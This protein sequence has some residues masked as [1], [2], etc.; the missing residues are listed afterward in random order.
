[1]SKI[2]IQGDMLEA[3][4]QGADVL[5]AHRRTLRVPLSAIEAVSVGIPSVVLREPA[6][7]WGNY[8]VGEMLV[9]NVDAPDGQ[10]ESFFEVRNPARAL[11][12]ELSRGRFAF[13]VLEPSNT[14]PEQLVEALDIARGH[15]LPDAKL[16]PDLMP[17]DLDEITLPHRAIHTVT[18]EHTSMNKQVSATNPVHSPITPPVTPNNPVWWNDANTSDWERVK[19]ALRRDWEQT[20]ADFSIGNARELNQN[21]FDTL[22]QAAGDQPVPL[23]T[24]KTRPDT[25]GELA[26]RVEKSMKDRRKAEENIAEAQTDMAVER[27]RTEAKVAEKKAETEAKVAKVQQSAQ[28]KFDAQQ[29]KVVELRNEAFEKIADVR[30]RSGDTITRQQEK[31]DEAR[32]D[33]TR[34]EEAMRYGFNV[35]RQYRD[36]RVWNTKFE[37]RLRRE[38]TELNNGSTWESA[39]THVRQ[40][41][42]SAARTQTP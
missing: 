36:E 35:Q 2:E 40:G 17:E 27:V 22:R 18:Q 41:W 34:A 23:T 28:E 14:E 42:E 39:R 1:M 5:R 9:G 38:W 15:T 6:M 21:A 12:L 4:M 32:S 8:D 13:V 20:K 37:D 31:L 26:A 10:R 11:T 7:L 30:A 16:P 19:G 24:V 29:N 25:P 33:W 3:T